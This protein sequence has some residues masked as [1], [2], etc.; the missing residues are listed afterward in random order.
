[1]YA[2]YSYALD[3]YNGL[4]S[5]TVIEYTM[6]LVHKVTSVYH[7]FDKT[8]L[9]LGEAII[10]NLKQTEWCFASLAYTMSMHAS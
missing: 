7:R 2:R 6:H 10:N 9:V 5:P 8:R 3:I 1:M 4:L